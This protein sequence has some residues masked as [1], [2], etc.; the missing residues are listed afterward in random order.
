MSLPL[1]SLRCEVPGLSG[2]VDHAQAWPHDKLKVLVSYF[3]GRNAIPLGESCARAF[4][5][6]GSE[7][8]RFDSGIDSPFHE[9][10]FKPIA[11]LARIVGY[12]RHELFADS[13]WGNQAYRQRRL[14]NAVKEFR[15]DLLLVIRGH[16]FDPAFIRHL[17]VRYD[18]GS[19][20]CW[21]VKGPKW[22]DLMLEEKGSYDHYFCIHR[23]GYS[24]T[25]GIRHLSALAVDDSLYRRLDRG[26][27]K[28]LQHDIVFVGSWNR[29]RQEIV[30]QLSDF[31]LELYGPK[32]RR[33]NLF[34]PGIARMV[35]ANGIWGDDLC[36]LYNKTKIALNISSWDTTASSGLNLRVFDT[37]ACGTFLLTDY[38]ADLT[39][40]FAVGEEIE[41]YASID[42]LR[43]K[44]RYYLSKDQARE[45]IAR[46]GYERV[47]K[48][49][50]YREKMRLMLKDVLIDLG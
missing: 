1:K 13:S 38:S 42:E 33:R 26:E 16:G 47:T 30:E 28:S 39:S 11:K 24:E 31:P 43:D 21:W 14:E 19:T 25:D 20:V 49:G 12:R 35:R 15:P 18:I 46:R 48:L 10:V 2:M 37:L 23:G 9:R 22:F 44:L 34:N 17:R 41:T 36:T 50:T 27:S 5:S 3:F 7:V 4:E 8:C 45:R 6:L 40:F 29:R 32:W